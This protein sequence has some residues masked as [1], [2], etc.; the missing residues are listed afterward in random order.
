MNTVK[1]KLKERSYSILSGSPLARLGGFLA[2]E[3]RARKVFVITNTKVNALY[4]ASVTKSLERAGFEVSRAI[5]PDGERYKTLATVEKLYRQAVAVRLDRRSLILA[6]GG[7]VVGDVAGF[8]AATYMRGVPFVQVPTTLLAMVDSS[9]GGKTGVDLPEGKNLVGAFY[10][11]KA[12]WIDPSVLG[13]LPARE[14]RNGLAEVI[15]YGVIADKKLFS[16]L[17]AALPFDGDIPSAVIQRCCEIKARVVEQDEY[18]EKGLREI[19]NFG[20]TFGHAVETLTGY[21]LYRHGEAVAIG[22]NLAGR[23]AVSMKLFSPEAQQRLENL[24]KAAG[25]PL[26]PSKKLSPNAMINAMMKD[27][28]TREK[29]L[30]LVLPTAIGKVIVASDIPR[31]LLRGVLLAGTNRS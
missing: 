16:N 14:V 5:M 11:P 4:A 24:L 21:S 8:V 15:K 18:E 31:G 29:K 2:G 6:L 22:M 10:Q 27:K 25:L 26:I 7:G 1:V 28:K 13:T 23:L 20:H 17:E 9:V 19:L 12:V 30:R 3:F